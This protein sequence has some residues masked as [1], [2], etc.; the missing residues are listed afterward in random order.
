M[1]QVSKLLSPYQVP[2]LLT[3][4][5][6]QLN[7]SRRII[8][9]L[10]QDYLG[11]LLLLGLLHIYTRPYSLL[12][13]WMV[14]SFDWGS[15]SLKW[16]EEK[17]LQFEDY[18]SFFQ[19]HLWI[20]VWVRPIWVNLSKPFCPTHHLTAVQQ[21]PS[22]IWTSPQKQKTSHHW[23][24]QFLLYHWISCSPYHQIIIFWSR[25]SHFLLKSLKFE[26]D[27]YFKTLVLFWQ[28]LILDR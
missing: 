3:L 1:L 12:N 18:F 14:I 27:T 10:F 21:L 24:V 25:S 8:P 6:E 23:P 2:I 22:Q 9:R 28:L 16:E 20:E 17:N 11:I 26:I 5:L 13:D 4:K 7:F 15:A 19:F